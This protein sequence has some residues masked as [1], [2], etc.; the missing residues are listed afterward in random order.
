MTP[1]NAACTLANCWST[2]T[3]DSFSSSM[4]DIPHLA[5]D[6]VQAPLLFVPVRG[7]K[8]AIPGLS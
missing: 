6:P 1:R 2:F 4:R 7:H 8:L 5:F 3:L